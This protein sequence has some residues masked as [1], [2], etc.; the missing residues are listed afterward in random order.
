MKKR[1]F[2]QRFTCVLLTLALMVPTFVMGQTTKSNDFITKSKKSEQEQLTHKKG[3]KM[4]SK[5]ME[6]KREI[7][8]TQDIPSARDYI[9][10]SPKKNASRTALAVTESGATLYGNLIY[11]ATWEDLSNVGYY[12]IDPN[13]GVYEVVGTNELLAGAG[14]VVDGIAYVSYADSFWGMIFGLYTLVYDVE[15]ATII[16]TI[17]H[18]YEDLTQ[19]A[20]N[21]A[22]DYLN[23]KIYALTYTEDGYDLMLSEFDRD[24]Y[25]YTK[26]TN[27]PLAAGVLAM[28]F[29]GNG[30][31]YIINDDGIIRELNPNTG[32]V[33]REVCNSGFLPYY[34][35][36][37]C[38]SFKDNK[39]LWAASNDYES[40]IISVDVTTGATETLCTFDNYEEWTSLYT[41]DP[42][43]DENAPAAPV[44][45]YNA[46]APGSLLGSI[47]VE[48]PTHNVGGEVLTDT[49]YTLVVELN[50]TELFN[51][52][53][54]PGEDVA[55]NS[56]EFIEGI[57]TIR[58]YA[59]NTA[60]QG[61]I[62][63][64][65]IYAGEDTPLPVTNLEV[66]I[67]DDGKASLSWTAPTEGVN[68]GY[69]NTASLTYTIERSGET[70]ATGVTNNYYEEQLPSEL[71]SYEWRVYA[72]S[73]NKV[74]QPTSTGSILFGSSVTLPYEQTFDNEACLDLYHIVDN[75]AD[76][77]TW[78]YD[79]TK[80]ALLY[81]YSSSFDA[82]D[83]AFTP[84]LQLS[85][86]NMLLVEINASAYSSSYPERIEITLGS[87]TNPN[88]QTVV[89]PATQ[90]DSEEAQT[91]R[92][93]F[94]VEEAGDYYIGIHAVSYA[95]QFY[96]LVKDIKVTEGPSFDAP[97]AVTDVTATAGANGA[98]NATI[99]FKAP[100]Q[101]LGGDALTENVTITVY[102]NDEIVGTTTLAPGAE[103]S[104]TDSNA[105][106]GVNDYV[107]VTSNSVGEG[108]IYEISCRCGVDTPSYVNDITFTTAADNMSSV[109]T[110]TAPTVGANGG[111]INPED[112][113][114][115]IYVPTADGYDVEAIGETTGLSYEV[116]TEDSYLDSY[117][118]YISAKNES[119]ESG[120]YGGSVVLG[121]PYTMPFIEEIKGT[122]LVNSPWLLYN[123]DPTSNA[124]WGLGGSL[125][126]YNLPETVTAPDGGMAVCYDDYEL[127]GG[128]C[129]LYAPKV[130][131]NGGTAPT[132]YFAMYHY[133]G[134]D[135]I[136]ELSVSITT[137]DAS[138]NEIFAKK[139]N[140]TDSYGWVE[141][142]VSLDEYKDAPW[143]GI[144]FDATISTNGFVFLDYVKVENASEND[145]TVQSI[146]APAKAAI[147]E[148]VEVKATIFNKGTNAAAFDVAFYL[149]DEEIEN[150][151]G[152]ELESTYSNEYTAK[153]TPT[154][155]NI[156]TV[157][158][159]VVVTMTGAEDEVSNNNEATTTIRIEQPSL[160]V[161]TDLAA[162]EE[163]GTVTLTW[164]EPMF[165]TEEIVDDMEAYE[166]FA[167]DNIGDYTLVDADYTETYSVNGYVVPSEYTPKA[168]QVWA[169]AEIGLTSESWLPYEGN[170][171][172]IAFSTVSGAANDW[173]ISPEVAG[174][175]EFSFWA[176]I[177]TTQYGSEN[178]EVL[179]STSNT[180]I[181]S[182][183]LIAQESKGTTN[184][185]Q[186]SYTLPNDAKYFAI[187]YTS[188]DIFALLIDN[189]SYTVG[190]ASTD[191]AVEGYNV[192]CNGNKINDTDVTEATYSYT[193]EESGNYMFNVTVIYNE[194]ESQ[195]SNTVTV[196]AILSIDDL[197]K[198]GIN[199]YG[200][201]NNI[202]I[203]NVSGRTVN[204]YTIEG[205]VVCK[206]K[207][208]DSDIL[209]PAHTGVYI[210]EI[211]N[212][213]VSKVIVR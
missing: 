46:D 22:Y 13:S 45:H 73:G 104:I 172:L 93:Y 201:D 64:V 56:V 153:F 85:N 211:D 160:P 175:T 49:E 4:T 119:G 161:V 122:T 210:V 164:S 71:A 2:I 8:P 186:Y 136:N 176:A 151:E 67:A 168:W 123:A 79:A 173:L 124:T 199:I 112:L 11:H 144:A 39:I 18:N 100:T 83:Y 127:T 183:Q 116:S 52:E 131:L 196:E 105:Q 5:M 126:N 37:A 14:T 75:N 97:A 188:V 20:V 60:G 88:E 90:L 193:V 149:N 115:T 47:T 44:V 16:E 110:W 74:S 163:N 182:F 154:A 72:V 31:F 1:T 159:K 213:V 167:I 30:A 101:T 25:T 70:I 209:I 152:E 150:I 162:T 82:D 111:Y 62:A 203:E 212:S 191:M 102:R 179:Y 142:S 95:D 113:V 208:N 69:L 147:G 42:M 9:K 143:I 87:S 195:L 171:C 48:S 41:T 125:E 118:Y 40:Y 91:L 180:D 10:P 198:L 103:G 190:N 6:L 166:S 137:D 21:M 34:M 187:R 3:T 19:Y 128:E 134:A 106:N 15:N 55:M 158:V 66:N 92:A 68:G 141:Y 139:I 53:L 174:G 121:S 36:S 23:D 135:D 157:T 50:N 200:Q 155:D 107:I 169:P 178:F 140:D 24:T 129:S 17:E 202:K 51:N 170:K 165:S 197:N 63:V 184:W 181:N 78:K 54:T 206:M 12:S 77:Y 61:D 38:W 33:I 29:D 57:N 89:I 133:S 94:S 98:L 28:T 156:G 80:V 96:L 81:P 109:M 84:P 192:F 65:K 26:V 204:V 146:N 207:S 189:I 27:F 148:E 138:F 108:D 120:L 43:A 86:E 194:G 76:G 130:T 205:K 117:S 32:E 114:Y 59:I 35:Q 99:A 185:E 145:I 132:L 7:K 177:P 58:S